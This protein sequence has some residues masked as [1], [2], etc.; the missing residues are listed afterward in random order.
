LIQALEAVTQSGGTG[1][2][3]VLP[4]L[5]VAGKTGT[6][7][8]VDAETG[9][10]SREKY[11]AS[12]IGFPVDVEPK[13][14]IF[15]SVTEPKGS[16]YASETAAPL[17]REVLKSVVNRCSLPVKLPAETVL[18]QDQSYR[19]SI[20]LAQAGVESPTAP[21]S[22]SASQVLSDDPGS[23]P[24]LMGLTP[25]E[26]FRNFKGRQFQ[27]EISGSGVVHGQFPA[28]GKPLVEGSV[29]RLLLSE[30]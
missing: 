3:A 28:P 25:R 29:I 17:F 14:V 6:A 13:I 21:L 20:R 10:Y 27:W 26:V 18:A 15:A 7:Q 23:T 30:P 8:M 1:T 4:G 19:D 12:F 22:V 16:Y 9:K 2:H 5:I 24:S 11:I